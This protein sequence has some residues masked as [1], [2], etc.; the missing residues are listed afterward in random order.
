MPP[1]TTE[2]ATIDPVAVYVGLGANLG[3][4]HAALRSAL[5]ALAQLPL[6]E[7]MAASPFYRSAPIDAGGP[8]YTNAVAAIATRL[9]PLDLLARLQGIED[10][11]GR[12]RPFPNAPRRLD[13][14]ILLYADR[15]ITLPQLRVP[16]PRMHERAFVLRPL[17]DL[18]P[19]LE[20]PGR[21]HLTQ[22]LA[23]VAGQRLEPI[24]R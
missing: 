13:L 12:E 15:C 17:A 4:T 16:H 7:F 21:G 2:S 14:D 1:L 23:G 8:D 6:T 11:H 3:D 19:D 24:S 20:I 9:S 5:A 22:L 10:E 18:A